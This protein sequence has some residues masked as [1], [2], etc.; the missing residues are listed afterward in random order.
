MICYGQDDMFDTPADIRVN[1]VNCVGV[2]G[3][4]IALAFKR[5]YP[6][7]FKDYVRACKA[8][9]VRPGQP[10]VWEKSDFDER[11]TVV[12]LPTKEHWR[13]PSEYEYV[14]KGLRWLHDFV[15]KRGSV[16]V[17]IPA[18]GCGHGGLEWSRVRPM[19]EDALGD[20]D[21]QITIFGPSSSRAAGD[22]VDAEALRELDKIG[23]MRLRPGDAYYPQRLRGRSDA[24]IYMEGDPRA[25]DAP[26]VAFLPSIKPSDRE[27]QAVLAC[28]REIARPS[29][30]V[31]VGYSAQVERPVI[32]VALEQGAHVIICLAEGILQFSVRRDLQDIWDKSRVTIIS[33]AKPTQKWFR[34]GAGKASVIELALA[35][36]AIVSDPAPAWL[37][38]FSRNDTN[39]V[40]GAL[41]FLNYGE[42]RG[43]VVELLRR[44]NARLIGRSRQTGR[45]NVREVMEI[46][47]EENQRKA[48]PVAKNE[49]Q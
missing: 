34:G 9:Q 47:S 5:R 19:M 28:V 27:K 7:M 36:V 11:V 17:A 45:P 1:T 30:S 3:A 29:V 49:S 13:Q 18:L 46:V 41:F 16:R 23:I 33:A 21:A 39:R 8:G 38:N 31:L 43:E 26:V 25:I 22:R 42:E 44:L 32:R 12:N 37:R 2:M 10:H 4:G 6:D 40:Q 48:V 20:L 14:K 35:D 15:A 24:T